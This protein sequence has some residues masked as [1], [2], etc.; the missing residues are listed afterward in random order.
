MILYLDTSA[1]VKLFIDEPGTTVVANTLND[2]SAVFTHIIAYAEAH[3]ALAKA[4]R[5]RRITEERLVAYK[6]ALENYWENLEVILPNMAC[7]K[8]AGHLAEA[9]GLRGYDSVHLAAAELIFDQNTAFA[10]ACFD[11]HLNQAAS[12]LGMQILA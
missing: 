3:A 8:Q 12:A 4:F 2:A 7:I 5:M 6:A 10:F 1:L 9:H 11:R